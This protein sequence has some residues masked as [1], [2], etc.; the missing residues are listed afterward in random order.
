M[1]FEA[2]RKKILADLQRKKSLKRI[3]QKAHTRLSSTSGIADADPSEK[4]SRL[5]VALFGNKGFFINNFTS[6]L[7]GT[8]KVS[9]FSDVDMTINYM[10]DNSVKHLIVDIDPPSD[11]HLGVNLFTVAKSIGAGITIIV[12]TMNV[13]DS[14]ALSLS[15]HG[16]IVLQKPISIP[17][18][19]KYI[20]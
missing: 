14:R 9:C 19:S 8:Y 1:N 16:C 12:C 10:M 5:P 13:E 4:K 15:D 17:D 7:S 2:N 20:G 18:L 6:S 3:E 11:Y